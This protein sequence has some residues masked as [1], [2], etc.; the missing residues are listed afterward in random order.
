VALDAM[1]AAIQASLLAML[2]DTPPPAP[3]PDAG[4]VLT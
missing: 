1:V 4:C 2:G 3:P